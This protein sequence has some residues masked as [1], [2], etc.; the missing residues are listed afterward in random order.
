MSYKLDQELALG[1]LRPEGRIHSAKEIH[2][3]CELR[4]WRS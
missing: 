4:E 2:L 1:N 3:T